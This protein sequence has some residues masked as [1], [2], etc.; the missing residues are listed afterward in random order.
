MV[1]QLTATCL[2]NTRIVDNFRSDST[3]FTVFIDENDVKLCAK[4]TV[5]WNRYDGNTSLEVDENVDYGSYPDYGGDTPSK[6]AT[7]EYTL[8]LP[9]PKGVITP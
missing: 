8:I 5:S 9:T 4:S 3:S 7:P 6:N 2:F 1:S